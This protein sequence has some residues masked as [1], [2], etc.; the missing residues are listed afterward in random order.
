[1]TWSVKLQ[2]L[3]G[4]FSLPPVILVGFICIHSEW[5]EQVGYLLGSVKNFLHILEKRKQRE[6]IWK[7]DLQATI[8][9]SKLSK[10]MKNST[11]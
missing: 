6:L 7:T 8:L 1:M 4:R 10:N 2:L 3:V 9:D 11:V 5:L